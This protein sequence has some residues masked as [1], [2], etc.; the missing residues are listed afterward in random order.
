MYRHTFMLKF[1]CMYKYCGCMYMGRGPHLVR[2]RIVCVCGCVCCVRTEVAI[3]I[4]NENLLKGPYRRTSVH[5]TALPCPALP[6]LAMPAIPSRHWHDEPPPAH[7]AATAATQCSDTHGHTHCCWVRS[8]HV[9]C[10]P[11]AG[12]T[13]LQAC[14]KFSCVCT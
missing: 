5:N 14:I 2:D 4:S 10:P 9:V 12:L 1:T 11:A 8:R 13:C 7:H 6:C 3:R